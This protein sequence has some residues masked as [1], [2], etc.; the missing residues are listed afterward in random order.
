MKKQL[1]VMLLL[2]AVQ[3][4]AQE[5]AEEMMD[6]EIVENTELVDD[7]QNFEAVVEETNTVVIQ[8]IGYT[9]TNGE[10][11]Y[12]S[13]RARFT[14]QGIDEQSGLKEILVSIDGSDYAPYKNPISF[15]TEGDHSLSYKFV[16]RVGNIS[17]SKVFSLT[18][19]AT[20]PRVLEVELNPAPYYA[21][22]M[23]YVGVN[24]EISFRSYD[25]MVGVAF[26][27]FASQ[28]QEMIRFESNTTFGM[29]GY[30]NTGALLLSYQATDM[31]SN[32]SP[33]KSRFFA[34]DATAPSLD[35]FAKAVEI[36]GI[37]YISSRDTIQIEAYDYETI[38]SQI[39]Y[40]INDGE[41]YPYD[42]QIGIN[43]KE[44]GEYVVHAKAM[45]IVGN[46]SA[47]VEYRVVVDILPPAGDT[48]YIGE[49]AS[50]QYDPFAGEDENPMEDETENDISEEMAEMN[51]NVSEETPAISEEMTDNNISEEMPAGASVDVM[52]T[53]Q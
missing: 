15:N 44:S 41:F 46:E 38:V 19:D 49:E 43:L 4:N 35:V 51:M 25:D 11:L 34:V 31:V 29:L 47:V 48:S 3:L 20:A 10:N 17:Y 18:V 36:D 14:V 32:I 8:N 53:D 26:V 28:D 33:V 23:E 37:R 5:V 45:D 2:I 9:M 21:S 6:A 30:T 50:T 52:D 13:P 40:A 42:A 16:D 24:T 12:A 27:E 39:M 1:L 7:E 22:G